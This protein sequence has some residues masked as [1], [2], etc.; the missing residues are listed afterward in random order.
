MEIQ[1][2]HEL[3]QDLGMRGAHD[4]DVSSSDGDVAQGPDIWTEACRTLSRQ[5]KI[6]RE[7]FK[8][9]IEPLRFLVEQDGTVLI[10]A[11]TDYDFSRV[12]GNHVLSIHNAWARHDE[13]QR[14]VR[15]VSW[16]SL[17]DDL[18]SLIKYP[19][20]D[21]DLKPEDDQQSD[22]ARAEDAASTL[23]GPSVMRFETLVVGESN[24]VA[25]AMA[26]RI[27]DGKPVPA[28]LVT[29]NG[30]QGVGKTHLM[31]AL[32]K[33]LE[34]QGRRRVAFISAE[35]FLVA[36]VEG[37]I[38]RDTSA[39]KARVRSADIVLFDDLQ[40]VAGKKGT[41]R[42]LAATLRTVSERGGIVILTADRPLAE[43]EGL[44]EAV[45]TVLRGAACIQVGLPDDEMRREIVRQRAA[46]LQEDSPNFVLDDGFCDAMVHRVY[47]PGRDLCGTLLTL[48]TDT[49]FGERA[50]TLDML[51]AAVSRKQGKLL[52][53]SLNVI[54][55][56]VREHFE[57]AR[58]DLEGK[59]RPKLLAHGRSIGMYL[60]RMLTTKS[61][62]QIGIAYGGRHHTTIMHNY[63]KIAKLI[64]TD[65]DVADEVMRIQ[66]AIDRL[67]AGSRN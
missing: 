33:R 26:E 32:E 48:Y 1:H 44:S 10:G 15:V 21:E 6:D 31:K 56:A 23:M 17:N 8:H 67:N 45:R 59:A 42:E 12:N 64:K 22:E 66:R 4:T 30:P 36:Y 58:G 40:N 52:A 25:V 2:N 35:E 28:S 63:R 7:D 13:R 14:P 16:Q 11:K 50:P 24:G 38:N 37:A 19:W 9:W 61:Y 55:Q 60:S 46:M 41:N 34:K 43:L 51:D 27:A 49:K 65:P 3:G 47:G 29:I 20:T 54:K 57:F 18:K 5:M 53:P 62:P 39:L